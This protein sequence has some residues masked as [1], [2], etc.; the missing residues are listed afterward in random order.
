MIYIY[1]DVRHRNLARVC[2][3]CNA[4]AQRPNTFCEASC[5]AV[6]HPLATLAAFAGMPVANDPMTARPMSDGHFLAY[7]VLRHAL[8]YKGARRSNLARVYAHGIAP[9]QRPNT[10]VCKSSGFRMAIPCEIDRAEG[11][12][13]LPR[14][15]GAPCWSHVV[16]KRSPVCSFNR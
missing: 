13:L 10:S 2:A 7:D 9:A 1:N 8:T 6:E 12:D 16:I 14:L 5:L 4:A 3:H 11:Q 15:V